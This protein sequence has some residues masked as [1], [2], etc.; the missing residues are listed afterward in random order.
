MHFLRNTRNFVVISILY[1]LVKPGKP[2]SDRKNNEKYVLVKEVI[3]RKRAYIVAIN[4]SWF[5]ES[6]L[7]YFVLKV[8]YRNAWLNFGGCFVVFL[9]FRKIFTSYKYITTIV[10]FMAS[11][12]CFNICI[13]KTFYC[14]L[15]YFINMFQNF[16][17]FFQMMRCVWVAINKRKP[18]ILWFKT[19]FYEVT[20][21]VFES[22][23]E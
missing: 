21:V 7:H 22:H 15:H 6:F 11:I 12:R 3:C 10:L 2:E 9:S 4:W 18:Y 1:K 13:V 20:R 8:E 17:F 23:S 14:L 16:F 5:L 19:L